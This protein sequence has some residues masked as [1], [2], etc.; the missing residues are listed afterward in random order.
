[1]WYNQQGSE[2]LGVML[3]RGFYN[4]GTFILYQKALYEV[5]RYKQAERHP[6]I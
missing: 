3:F 4:C 6:V 5:L 1:M 2:N